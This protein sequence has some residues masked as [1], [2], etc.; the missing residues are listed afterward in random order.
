M[1]ISVRM[2]SEYAVRK[3]GI[4]T[5]N[6][7]TTAASTPPT[8]R[9]AVALLNPVMPPHTLRKLRGSLTLAPRARSYLP[10]PRL[11]EQAL[12]FQH[13]DD[14]DHEQRDRRRARRGDVRAGEVLHHAEGEPA[15]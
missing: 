6:A 1:T 5:A 9:R 3:F 12:W 10:H 14:H 2:Y 11:P 15:H 7:M 4:T 8:D 13:E